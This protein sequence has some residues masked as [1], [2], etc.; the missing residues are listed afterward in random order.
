MWMSMN[1]FK[2]VIIRL[3][4]TQRI[5]GFGNWQECRIEETYERKELVGEDD[6]PTCAALSFN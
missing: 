2:A 3:L 5:K 6:W 4:G 1:A